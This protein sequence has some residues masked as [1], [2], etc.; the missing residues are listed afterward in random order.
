MGDYPKYDHPPLLPPGRHCLTLPEI[1]QLCVGGFHDLAVKG[2]R[3]TLYYA[4]E[5]FVQALL[6][7]K[8]RCKVLID[9]S[10]LTE[11]PYPDD[12]DAFVA[13]DHDAYAE[14]AED[15]MQLLEKI[16]SSSGLVSLV[17]SLAM[18]SYP[19]GHP[20]CGTALDGGNGG[21]A[22]GIEHSQR[23]LKGYVVVRVWETDVGNRICR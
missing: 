4:L 10:F 2:C 18:T 19:C 17:D 13:I 22:Y 21:E 20:N 5:E 15:Q 16:N 23:W 14:L 12:V 8:I 7:G 3:E 11:K 9:G 1:E 6:V